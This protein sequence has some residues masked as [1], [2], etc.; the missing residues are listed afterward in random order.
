VLHHTDEKGLIRFRQIEHYLMPFLAYFAMDDMSALTR[1]DV[2]RLAFGAGT[3]DSDTLPY[4][5]SYLQDFESRYCYD[6]YREEKARQDRSM[7]RITCSGHAFV[8]IGDHDDAFFTDQER[9]LL[10]QFRHQYFL[11]GLIA[12]FHKAALLLLSDRL[13]LAV[14]NLEIGDAESVR[15]FRRA[16]RQ[17]FEIFLRFSHRYWFHEVSDQVPMRDLFA[18]WRRH[19]DTE[20]L[21]R[22]VREELQDMSQY[23]DMDVF[24]RHSNTMV[25]LTVVTILGL[26]GTVTTGFLGMN[27][28]GAADASPWRKLLYFVLVFIPSTALTLYTVMKSRR[29]SEFL[30]SLSNER[31]S[32]RARLRTLSA[33]WKR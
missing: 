25:R 23:L 24:R 28:I 30:D 7:T 2:V 14:S 31:L 21:F 1:A 8:M 6:R 32:N 22:D 3:G 20:N 33:V 4:S 18:M 10:G 17:T 26:I 19:L 11:L 29:L 15:A 12:H 13:V 16:I 5:T 9:G 27:L